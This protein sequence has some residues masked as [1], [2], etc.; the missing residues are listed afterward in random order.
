MPVVK[1]LKE[2]KEVNV[3]NGGNLRVKA[4]ENGVDIYTLFGKMT[5][6]GGAGQCATCVVEVTEGLENLSPRTSFEE[7]KLKKKPDAYRLAC[8]SQV[9]GPITVQTKPG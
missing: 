4:I 7:R 2:G 8:Q 6:C 9:N 1:F 3:A 5:N